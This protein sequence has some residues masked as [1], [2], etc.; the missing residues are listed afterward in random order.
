MR[1]SEL[2]AKSGVSAHRLR[3]YESLGLI[4]GERTAGGYR[5]FGE[6][7]LREVTF[8]AMGRELGFSLP[9][10]AELLP[11]YR[12]KTL[13][14]DEM[15]DGLQ[16]RIAEIDAEIAERKALR[17][18][19]VEHIGWFERRRERAAAKAKAGARWPATPK[20]KQERR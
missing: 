5:K 12:A 20:H 11:R 14:I 8:I 15:V 19:L 3:R 7:T 4:V 13:S 9:Q 10:L 6:A 2:A 18:R 1:I 17:Q 16:R